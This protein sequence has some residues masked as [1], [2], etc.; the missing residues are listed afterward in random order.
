MGVP[1]YILIFSCALSLGVALAKHGEPRKGSHDFF[2]SLLSELVLFS[3]LF[4]GGFF[5]NANAQVPNEAKRWRAD[6]TRAA[7]AQWGLNA[8]IA[9]LAAQIHQESHWKS[10]AVS[11]VGA[12]GMAQFMPGTASWWCELNGLAKQDCQPTNPVWA[13]RA[14]VGY[15][16]WLFDRIKA[17]DSRNQHA[18]MLSAYNGGLGWIQRDKKLASSKG[19]DP[20]VWFGS[21]EL[22]NAGRAAANWQEN[23]AYP[24]RILIE[25][26]PIYATWGP[27][28]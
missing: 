13:I 26:Q 19:L 20:L 1:Q 27:S 17:S 2:F 8:P 12:T 3:I 9:T 5:S 4:A 28:V 11:R 18:F 23:R 24:K 7:H 16:R 14:L 25:L 21:V 22:V 15:D 6:L 10:N